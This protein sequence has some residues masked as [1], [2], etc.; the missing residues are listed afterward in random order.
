MNSGVL[1]L[2][3]RRNVNLAP[4]AA[5]SECNPPVKAMTACAQGSESRQVNR[6]ERIKEVLI[7]S[8]RCVKKV[9]AL[10]SA[11]ELQPRAPREISRRTTT[12]RQEGHNAG[13]LAPPAN[14]TSR[15]PAH[16]PHRPAP[17]FRPW[18][19]HCAPPSPSAAC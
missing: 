6:K 15:E 8:I 2:K 17:A 14:D 1:D 12:W 7:V 11:R 4:S 5:G 19:T 9:V 18:K 10:R 13:A 3:I 16:R